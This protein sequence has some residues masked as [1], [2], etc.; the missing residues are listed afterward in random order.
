MAAGNTYTQIASTTLGSNA[1]SVTFSSIPGTYTDLVLVVSAADTAAGG[2]QISFRLNSNATAIYSFTTVSGNGTSAVSN[3]ETTAAGRTYGTIAWNTAT[4][5]TLGTSNA[6][7]NF[8]NYSNSTTYKTVLSRGNNTTFGTD[9]DVA[10]CQLTAAVTSIDL[11]S[12]N[13]GRQFLAGSTFNLYG[14]TAA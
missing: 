14:I 9:A 8:M 1:S 12:A 11:Y 2:Q 5:T 7:A 6:I 13:S 4:N 3:R 10:L